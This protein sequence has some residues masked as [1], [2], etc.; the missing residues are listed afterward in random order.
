M[1]VTDNTEYDE[2]C[3]LSVALSGGIFCKLYGLRRPGPKDGEQC[4]GRAVRGTS[5]EPPRFGTKGRIGQVPTRG[6]QKRIFL[7]LK[8][9][10]DI[11][12][13]KFP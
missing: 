2:A 12:K 3:T 1:P 5:I 10:S 4:Q 6:T 13:T 8:F 7:N 11:C 9:I